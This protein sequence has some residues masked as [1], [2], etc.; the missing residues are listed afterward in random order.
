MG[1]KVRQREEESIPSIRSYLPFL[2]NKL[3]GQLPCFGLFNENS[4][5]NVYARRKWF[6]KWFKKWFQC[7]F[8]IV[9][10]SAPASVPHS[11]VFPF[12]IPAWLRSRKTALFA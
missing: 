9:K 2:Q 11:A 10:R 7:P 6:R 3:G 4:K 12:F 1:G 8:A 5:V